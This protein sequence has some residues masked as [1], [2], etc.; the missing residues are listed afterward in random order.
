[1]ADRACASSAY[2]WTSNAPSCARSRSATDP[3]AASEPATPTGRSLGAVLATG[4][5][6][7]Q[8]ANATNAGTATMTT[9]TAR[10]ERAGAAGDLESV[11]GA[12]TGP[13]LQGGEGDARGACEECMRDVD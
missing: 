7:A 12:D 2:R 4:Q 11:G 1:M 13:Y 3:A 6:N 8:S 10:A 5:E 9:S